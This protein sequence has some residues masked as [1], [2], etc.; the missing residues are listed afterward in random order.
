VLVLVAVA[1]LFWDGLEIGLARSIGFEEVA[2]VPA[3]DEM[4]VVGGGIFVLDGGTLSFYDGKGV[5]QFRHG[6]GIRGGQLFGGLCGH[7]A[8]AAR[9]GLVINMYNEAGFVYTTFVNGIIRRL[10][11]GDGGLAVAVVEWG[12]G[13]DVVM[14]NPD[15]STQVVSRFEG[16]L[17]AATAV[18]ICPDG[19]VAMAMVDIGGARVNTIIT[20]ICPAGEIVAQNLHNPMQIIGQLN[21]LDGGVLLGISD[22]R[23]FGMDA[24]NGGEIWSMPLDGVSGAHIA[25][26]MFVL[27][28]K[29]TAYVFNTRGEQIF[30]TTKESLDWAHVG[31]GYVIVWGAGV[32]TAFDVHAGVNV[33]SR[34]LP[35]P[36][37]FMGSAARLAVRAADGMRIFER[38][39]R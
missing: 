17:L 6:H 38:T 27:I 9:G 26:D 11:V 28:I 37:D 3:G 39:G 23:I 33:W 29:D 31:F 21:F 15:G 25:R 5:Q 30:K 36:V 7:V 32:A 35:G 34:N 14:L 19:N 1:I 8:V 18:A 16:E 22:T 4:L 13:H 12:G 20:F 24:A 10:A 2:A